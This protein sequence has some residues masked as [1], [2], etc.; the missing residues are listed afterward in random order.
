MLGVDPILE[1]L[2]PDKLQSGTELGAK[3]GISRVAIKKRVDRL[4]AIGA[5][6]EVVANQG[7]RLSPGVVLL[8]KPKI[9]SLI[10]LED[11]S[12]Q[13]E[14]EVLASLSSTNQYLIDQQSNRSYKPNLISAVLSESQPEGQG[15]RGRSWV[16]AP[17]RNIT[18]SI[19]FIFPD[20]PDNPSAIS[21][22]FSVAV[23]RALISTLS[24]ISTDNNHLLLKWPNDLVAL[25]KPIKKLGGL[26][27]S[28]S[29]EAGGYFSMIMGVG[30]NINL[31]REIIT[32]IDQ[33]ATDLSLEGYENVDRNKLVAEIISN[34]ADMLSVY[35]RVG[36]EPFSQYWNK[37]GAFIGEQVRLFDQDREY[38]GTLKGVDSLGELI[39]ETER[40]DYHRFNRSELSLR[41][42]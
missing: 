16:S 18:L 29:G 19:G 26:L 14:V 21:L 13:V 12:Q 15:R 35:P 41:P 20:W 6:I 40:G 37:H 9:E 38:R 3:L 42:C 22:A 8:S 4:V 2:F 7:Y 5:P 11:K 10:E 34:T 31:G 32:Q 25:D 24:A 36:F 30:I 27:V 28:A 17:Y 23:H 1:L 39:L 33:P